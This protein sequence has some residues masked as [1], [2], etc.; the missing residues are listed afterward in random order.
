[1]YWNSCFHFTEKSAHFIAYGADCNYGA[2]KLQSRNRRTRDRGV[3]EF[4]V[5]RQLKP[6]YFERT[7]VRFPGAVAASCR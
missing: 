5:Q 2:V 3:A 6:M 4:P 1:M 7:L